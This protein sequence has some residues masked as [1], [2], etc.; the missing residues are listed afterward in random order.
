MS[1]FGLER[2][3]AGAISCRRCGCA[4]VVTG[5][6]LG[7]DSTGASKLQCLALASYHRG[8]HIGIMAKRHLGPLDVSAW[9]S[10]IVYL[11]TGKVGRRRAAAGKDPAAVRL[12]RLGGLK[13]GKARAAKLS[14]ERRSEI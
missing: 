3:R 1:G 6:S 14:V 7:V 2:F 8:S 12:G 13:G 4:Q 11:A 10:R 5:V 9:A